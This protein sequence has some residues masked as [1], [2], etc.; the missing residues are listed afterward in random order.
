MKPAAI[1]ATPRDGQMAQCPP[2]LARPPFPDLAAAAAIM[3]GA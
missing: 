1:E 2:G 3:A